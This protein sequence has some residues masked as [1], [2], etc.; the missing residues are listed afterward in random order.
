MK[1]DLDFDPYW[2]NQIS[3]E[4]NKFALRIKDEFD[5]PW[6]DLLT[7][8]YETRTFLHEVSPNTGI[9]TYN[10]YKGLIDLIAT[11]E[12]IQEI[13]I[14][15]NQESVSI[16]KSDELF[17]YFIRP[18]NRIKWNLLKKVKDGADEFNLIMWKLVFWD[19]MIFFRQTT[20]TK[21][22]RMIA[23]GMFL[24]HFKIYRG[25]PIQSEEEWKQTASS[26]RSWKNYLV[27]RVKSLSKSDFL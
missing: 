23:I 5:L 2:L 17:S 27:D 12:E 4:D 18:I 3:G 24:S 9:I 10:R 8:I 13:I 14:K 26:A 19:L 20:L 16:K 21:N 15:T 25:V 6:S 7:K 1:E 22:D 11:G